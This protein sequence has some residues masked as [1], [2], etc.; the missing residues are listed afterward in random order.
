MYQRMPWM[1][2]PSPT[3]LSIFPTLP[4]CLFVS[5]FHILTA[6][7]THRDTARLALARSRLAQASRVQRVFNGEKF[8][9]GC[10]EGTPGC[11]RAAHFARGRQVEGGALTHEL[12]EERMMSHLGDNIVPV[13]EARQ[14]RPGSFY[15]Q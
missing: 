11:G 9:E 13:D 10:P 15:G 3:P 7:P 6:S 14:Q 4:P 2:S 1:E 5:F 8:A 12:D